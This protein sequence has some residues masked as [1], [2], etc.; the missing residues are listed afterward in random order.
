MLVEVGIKCVVVAVA[1]S[2]NNKDAFARCV[3]AAAMGRRSGCSLTPRLAPRRKRAFTGVVTIEPFAAVSPEKAATSWTHTTCSTPQPV[4]TH[5][6][7]GCSMALRRVS[8]ASGGP[9]LVR[10]CTATSTSSFCSSS[11]GRQD[12]LEASSVLYQCSS[13]VCSETS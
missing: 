3:R 11:G 13:A 5:A 7:V 2:S 6:A 9:A 1:A 12:G 10:D 8:G 4:A